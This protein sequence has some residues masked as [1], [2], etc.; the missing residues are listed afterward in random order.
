MINEIF[1]W[2]AIGVVFALWLI[3]VQEGSDWNK[4]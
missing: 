2:I 4:R 1:Q 3:E